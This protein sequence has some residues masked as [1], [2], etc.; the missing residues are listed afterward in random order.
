ML[1]FQRGLKFLSTSAKSGENV[2]EAFVTLARSIL[3]AGQGK[4]SAVGAQSHR[5]HV[6]LGV[7]VGVRVCVCVFTLFASTAL[8]SWPVNMSTSQ[9]NAFRVEAALD[10]HVPRHATIFFGLPNITSEHKSVVAERAQSG[11]SVRRCVPRHATI[12]LGYPTY[13]LFPSSPGGGG[14]VLAR[15]EFGVV[16]GVPVGGGLYQ[17]GGSICV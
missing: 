11:G 15:W 3:Q 16:V 9:R 5:L 12:F 8:T 1:F 4:P 6:R 13:W 17:C 10:I 2:E 7:G 14:L